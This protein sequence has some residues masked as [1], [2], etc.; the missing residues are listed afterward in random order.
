MEAAN[1]EDFLPSAQRDQDRSL[2]VKFYI[3]PREDKEASDREGRPIF[4]DVEHIDIK[5]AG[6]K[7]AGAGRPATDADK[8]RFPEHYAAFKNRTSTEV[9]MGTPLTEWPPCSRSRAEELAYFNVKT[10]EQLA[11]MN[12]AQVSNFMG[13]FKLKEQAK[14]WLENAKSTK[15]LFDMKLQINQLANEN[16]ELKKQLTR[17]LEAVETPEKFG[18]TQKQVRAKN[19]AIHEAKALM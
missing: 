10:V 17:L 4:K 9:G 7:N 12:D 8:R 2:L 1:Y 13:L 15:P 19:T 5:I 11:T 3:K 18:E 14:V 16:E 6:N